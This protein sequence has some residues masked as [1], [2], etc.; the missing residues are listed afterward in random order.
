[1]DGTVALI[2]GAG[3][4]IGKAV[5]QELAAAGAVVVA[6]DL[7]IAEE[8][9]YRTLRCDVLRAADIVA[10]M[11]LC[12]GLG[13]VDVL[14]NSAGI[15]RRADPLRMSAQAWDQVIDV[16]VKGTFFVSQ[17]AAKSMIRHKRGGSIV[18]IGS[19]NAEKVFGDTVAYCSSKGAIHAMTRAMSLA[20]A[21][22]SI[23]V[24]TLAPGAV[25]DT[26]LEPERWQRD[27]EREAMVKRTP[28]RRLGASRDIASVALFLASPMSS[29]MTGATVFADGGRSASV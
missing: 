21:P 1:M 11:D 24:N 12:D 20:L 29:F 18:N 28:Q 16:N 22:F 4:G 10:A 7:S 9:D 3:R 6:T 27:A 17:A 19:I 14:V 13:G 8:A 5:A 26:D 2:T 15:I 25:A 23:R